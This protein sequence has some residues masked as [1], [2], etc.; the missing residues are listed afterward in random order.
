LYL[1][2][3]YHLQ[4][5]RST[6][7]KGEEREKKKEEKQ[8]AD[9]DPLF[10]SVYSW[11][12][13]VCKIR[14]KGGG[15]GEKGKGKMNENSASVTTCLMTPTLTIIS[16]VWK[17]SPPRREKKGGKKLEGGRGK[18]KKKKGDAIP[19]GL[20]TGVTREMPDSFSLHGRRK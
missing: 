18:K 1:G 9:S 6:S 20:T 14:K 5:K 15:K 19:Q 12:P 10:Y 7:W 13:P 17:S 3:L 2:W 11:S 16:E 4:R 8:R